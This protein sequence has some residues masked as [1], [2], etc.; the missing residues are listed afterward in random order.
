MAFEKF[1]FQKFVF[2]KTSDALSPIMLDKDPALKALIKNADLEVDLTKRRP[3]GT[4]TVSSDYV[5]LNV[6]FLYY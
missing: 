3:S 6:T 5:K 1:T 2:H 4:V